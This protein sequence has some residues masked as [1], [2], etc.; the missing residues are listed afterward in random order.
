MSKRL[1]HSDIPPLYATNPKVQKEIEALMKDGYEVHECHLCR[2]RFI[3]KADSK[4]KAVCPD[5]FDC[6]LH[7]SDAAGEEYELI[8]KLEVDEKI[9]DWKKFKGSA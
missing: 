1:K 6:F 4:A 7:F 2:Y 8:T 3:T 5:G 9:G